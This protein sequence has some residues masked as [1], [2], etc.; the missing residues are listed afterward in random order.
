MCG[1]PRPDQAHKD[2]PI[3]SFGGRREGGRKGGAPWLSPEGAG[4]VGGVEWSG[5]QE[6]EEEGGVCWCAGK[7]VRVRND[8][9]R[10]V[11]G[12][13]ECARKEMKLGNDEGKMKIELIRKRSVR[14]LEDEN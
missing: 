5:A 9:V 14:K 3:A 7:E 4:V 6:V 12:V 11:R 13:R 2:G 8:G 10:E 1:E